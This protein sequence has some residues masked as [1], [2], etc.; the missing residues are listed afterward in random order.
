MK[1]LFLLL[2]AAAAF[3][4]CDDDKDY[5]TANEEYSGTLTVT[6]LSDPSQVYTFDDK[7]F[8]LVSADDGTL[9]LWMHETQ[10]VPQMPVL[11]ME[12]PGIAYTRMPERL[13]LSGERL[14]P[15]MGGTPYEKYVITNL[16]GALTDAEPSDRLTLSFECMGFR[17]AYAGTE[18]D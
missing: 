10:F 11:T 17:V 8:S 13:N 2:F 4:A 9:T 3:A 1:K 16:A 6:L 12:V 5:G 15:K 18:T 14:V 7:R